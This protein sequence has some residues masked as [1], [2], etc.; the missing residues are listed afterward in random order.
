MSK[1]NHDDRQNKQ[2]VS[3][4]SHCLGDGSVKMLR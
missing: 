2:A 4:A 1:I 3:L